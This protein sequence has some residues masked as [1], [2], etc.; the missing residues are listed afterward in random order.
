MTVAENVTLPIL[1]E[2]CSTEQAHDKAIEALKTVHI[3]HRSDVSPTCLSKGQQQRVAIARA[4]VT[5]SKILVC[6]EP[7]S[8]LDHA[9]GIEIMGVLKDFAVHYKKSVLVVTHDQRTFSFAD[10]I[11]HISDGQIPLGVENE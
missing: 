3:A 6:D 8:A 2:G 1:I 4:I 11:I 7:T 5:N 10:R 9:A